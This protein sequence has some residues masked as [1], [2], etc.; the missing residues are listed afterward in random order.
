VIRFLVHAFAGLFGRPGKSIVVARQE[1]QNERPSD[2]VIKAADEV[3]SKADPVVPYDEN[4]LERARTQWQFGDWQ[5]LAQL[6]RD[7][8]QHH[9]DRAKLA[10]LAAAGRLQTGQEAEAKAYIRLAQ[11]WGVSKK[12]ISQILIAGVHNSIGRAAAIGNQQHRALKHFEYAIAIGSPKSERGLLTAARYSKQIEQIGYGSSTAE[13]NSNNHDSYPIKIN[14]QSPHNSWDNYLD[15]R[16]VRDGG[17]STEW[18]NYLN[19]TLIEVKRELLERRVKYK[20][21]FESSA[22]Q[23]VKRSPPLISII[24]A[25]QRQANIDIIVENVACQNHAKKE[26]IVITQSYSSDNVAGLR[27]KLEEIT[28]PL[29]RAI[30]IE[31]N[32]SS[33]LG[34][35]Q[36]KA[37][38]LIQ[39]EYWAKF[40]DDDRYFPNFLS[41][42][43]ATCVLGEYDLVA[44]GAAFYYLELSG[45][46]VIRCPNV[47]N[48]VMTNTN[49]RGSSFFAMNST[50]QIMRFGD[51]QQGEDSDLLRSILKAGLRAYASDPFN[52]L[53]TRSSNKSSHTF[54]RADGAILSESIYISPVVDYGVVIV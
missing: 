19:K 16:R 43:L 38:E 51:K 42:M 31:D 44:K 3:A 18:D 23:G 11:D 14:R 1:D 2:L 20:K 39:G 45:C 37:L 25:S 35:R 46:L 33:S 8:L 26:V 54:K 10:V 13:Q 30:V 49:L 28:P 21:H 29:K 22:S 36:N 53:V 34:F 32:S 4:L 47:V 24:C 50:A 5:S 52:Y 40:D 48:Q 41:D 7:T 12:L 9:P 6:N 17:P 27:R 15:A